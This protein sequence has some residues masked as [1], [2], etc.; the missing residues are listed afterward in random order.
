MTYNTN[1]TPTQ[2]LANRANAG[3]SPAGGADL[4]FA[5][6]VRHNGSRPPGN[7]TRRA[8][9]VLTPVPGAFRHPGP[10]IRRALGSLTESASPNPTLGVRSGL[11]LSENRT[12][13]V[14]GLQGVSV[15]TRVNSLR[16]KLAHAVCN[17]LFLYWVRVT[18][19]S[20]GSRCNR[21]QLAVGDSARRSVSPPAGS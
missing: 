17:C 18:D 7:N 5:N 3:S 6:F 10:Q 8:F 4:K 14:S 21:R 20:N 1:P 12:L 15:N 9:F 13:R 11:T 16:R 2:R 19:A